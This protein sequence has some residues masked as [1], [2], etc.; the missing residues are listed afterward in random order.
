MG[1]QVGVGH[2]HIVVVVDVVVVR[3]GRCGRA[4][5]MTQ[6][7]S[8][9]AF[10]WAWKRR[11]STLVFAEH[12]MRGGVSGQARGWW[13]GRLECACLDCTSETRRSESP[14]LFMRICFTFLRDGEV[15]CCVSARG[16]PCLPQSQRQTNTHKHSHGSTDGCELAQNKRRVRVGAGGTWH[17]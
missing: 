8:T 3:C 13:M 16:C 14:S 11:I 9:D 12:A 15:G 6:H 2:R 17:V 5:Q 10:F 1:D 4:K 7:L